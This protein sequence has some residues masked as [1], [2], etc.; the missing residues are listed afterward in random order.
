[1][2]SLVSICNRLAELIPPLVAPLNRIGNALLRAG[3][4]DGA[5]A[6][7]QKWARQGGIGPDDQTTPVARDLGATLN[8]IVLREAKKARQALDVPVVQPH[9]A[10]DSATFPAS[11][12]LEMA[13]HRK[14]QKAREVAGQGRTRPALTSG[15]SASLAVGRRNGQET[16]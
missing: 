13:R 12:T 15:A 10:H 5:T 4:I 8:E 9:L 7:A 11:R 1:M 6:L 2:P 3:G 16:H 14:A